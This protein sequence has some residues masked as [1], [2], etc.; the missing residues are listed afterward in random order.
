MGLTDGL[1]TTR[2]QARDDSLS[3]LGR[4]VV[5]IGTTLSVSLRPV[6]SVPPGWKSYNAHSTIRTFFPFAVWAFETIVYVAEFKMFYSCQFMQRR[7]LQLSSSVLPR[8]KHVTLP[9][10]N[11]PDEIFILCFT[12]NNYEESIS[13]FKIYK[14]YH[15]KAGFI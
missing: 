3:R 8:V 14:E 7:Q 4:L 1:W 6:L 11:T 2:C 15:W 12:V 10:G 13:K 5:K 9:W